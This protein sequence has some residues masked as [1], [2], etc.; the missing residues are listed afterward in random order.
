[1]HNHTAEPWRV[2]L[3]DTGAE[4]MTGGRIKRIAR[5]LEDQPFMLTYGDGVADVNIIDLLTYHRSHGKLATVTSIQP[6]GR[7][8]ALDLNS[9]N[10][11]HGFMEKPAGD[12]SWV[13]GGYFILE[14]RVLDRI[15]NDSTVFEKGPME[16]LARDGQLVAYKHSG[17]WQ[18]M[19]TMRDK[20][21]LEELWG[22]GKAPWKVW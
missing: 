10:V 8:G 2:T 12:G 7:F 17:F 3:V 16:S 14:P 21:Y 20:N 9:N 13:N 18:P 19:D 5:Y 22:T 1:V 6:A 15:T 4:T 11:V